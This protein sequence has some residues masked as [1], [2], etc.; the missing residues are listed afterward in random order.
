PGDSLARDPAVVRRTARLQRPVC[1]LPSR[2]LPTPLACARLGES[3]AGAM[4]L[5]RDVARG[6]GL[7]VLYRRP[8]ERRPDPPHPGDHR[9][10][11]VRHLPIA[12]RDG[13]RPT[14]APPLAHGR[15]RTPPPVA[16]AAVL[17]TGPRRGR[18]P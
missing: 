14:G 5:G 7:A 18:A 8:R 11:A 17:A 3:C 16:S 4:D 9:A 6:P 15:G 12:G 13:K 2:E 10:I 1:R